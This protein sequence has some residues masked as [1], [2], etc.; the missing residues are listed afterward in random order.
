MENKVQSKMI[1]LCLEALPL[2]RNV[3]VSINKTK[4][5]LLSR[6]KDPIAR[7]LL[8]LSLKYEKWETSDW[9]EK[10]L[11][12]KIPTDPQYCQRLSKIT[13]LSNYKIYYKEY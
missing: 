3:K 1:F 8:L 11:L 7:F 5:I 10:F 2:I 9:I 6:I 13:L 4:P 12:L